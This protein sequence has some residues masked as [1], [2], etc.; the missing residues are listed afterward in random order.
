M[1]FINRASLGLN[2]SHKLDEL[3]GQDAIV[4]C[5][6]ESSLLTCVYMGARLRAWI[7]PLLYKEVMSPADERQVLGAVTQDGE[8][9]L[10]PDIDKYQLESLNMDF[11]NVIEDRK[12]TAMTQLNSETRHYQAPFDRHVMNDRPVIL[13]GDIVTDR[14]ELAIARQLLR[15]LRPKIIYGVAGNV[16]VDVSDMFHIETQV[17]QLLDILPNPL[18]DDHYFEQP[19]PYSLEEKRK[20]AL[21]ISTFWV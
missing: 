9:C 16:S 11:F 3:R 8:F 12:R 1:Y 2:L 5:L 13:T 19:D 10:H 14:M 21:N 20:L 17:T 15:P 6:K 4:V 7:F 18:N